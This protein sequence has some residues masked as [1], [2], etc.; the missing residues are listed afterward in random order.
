MLNNWQQGVRALTAAGLL[1]FGTAHAAPVAYQGEFGFGGNGTGS[2]DVAS[3]YD[4]S[5]WQFWTFEALVGQNVS[6]TI[7][8]LDAGLDIVAAVWFG[9]E[10]DTNNYF[11]MISDSLSTTWYGQGDDWFG[12][13]ARIDFLSLGTG[14]YVVAVSTYELAAAGS[15][16]AISVAVPEP[17][18]YALM[19]LGLGALALVARRRRARSA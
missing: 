3:P 17:E 16:Y 5:A 4:T 2:L 6:V 15:G 12:P 18:T 10:G 8:G 1:A 13:D 9:Q 19:G 7:T 14:T 11:D